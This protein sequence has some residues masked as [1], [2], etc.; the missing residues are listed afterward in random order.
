MET[1]FLIVYFAALLV[2]AFFGM[3]GLVMVIHYL[4]LRPADP[5]PSKGGGLSRHPHVT[6]QLPLFNELH[7]AER[8]VEAVCRLN[9]PLDRLEIQ[10]LDDSTDSTTKMLAN[11]TR[12]KRRLG[13]N[14]HHIHRTNRQGFKAGALKEGLATATGEFI[15]IFDADFVPEPEFLAETI[16]HLLADPQ[17]GLVQARWEHINHDYSLLTRMQ[18]MALDAHFAMEQQVRN[19]AEYF[20]NFNG[21]AGIWRKSCILDAGNWESDTLTEDLDL[22]YRAQLRGWRFLY[23]NDVTV[24]AELPAEINGLKSQQFRWTKG[25]IETA[26]KHLLRVWLSRQPLRT[27]IHATFHLTSNIVFP[28]ILLVG[29][30]NVPMVFLKANNPELSRYFDLMSAFIFASVSSFLFYLFAQRDIRPDWRNRMFLFPIFMAGTMGLAVNNTKAVIEAVISHRSAF[31]RTPKYNIKR[32]GDRA[33]QRSAY[34]YSKV[35]AATPA[36]FPC[37][38]LGYGGK[39]GD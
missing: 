29:I 32:R 16:P 12:R 4:R 27:K 13:I 28:F 7:V 11:L 33:W 36:S 19:R 21:T 20:I 1:T 6:V 30:L 9:Y 34:R 8:L 37:A 23:L 18:A 25:A 26:K 22:S 10:I 5:T 24:P 2:L 31:N 15:A 38:T 35:S 17:L 14:I 39:R 3:Y